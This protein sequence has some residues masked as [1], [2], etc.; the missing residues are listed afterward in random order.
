MPQLDLITFFPQLVNLS[1][2]FFIFYMVCAYY[3]I[4]QTAKITKL[5]NKLEIYKKQE[6]LD[7]ISSK[8]QDF[9]NTLDPLFRKLFLIMFKI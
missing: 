4:P 1:I 6:I 8:R 7:K 5:S 9:Y 3:I 2:L